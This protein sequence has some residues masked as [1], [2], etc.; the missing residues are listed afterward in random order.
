LTKH[1]TPQLRSISDPT[2][3]YLG[4]ILTYF[5]PE[6]HHINLNDVVQMIKALIWKKQTNKKTDLFFSPSFLLIS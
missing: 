6:R 2:G 3:I 1:K 4:A 5:I